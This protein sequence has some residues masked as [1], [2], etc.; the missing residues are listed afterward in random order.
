[1]KALKDYLLEDF[2]IESFV[3]GDELI[4]E[5]AKIGDIHNEYRI[6]VNTDDPGYIPHFHIWD[7]KTKGQKFHTCVKYESC[8]YFHHHCKEDILNT[9]LK[10]ELVSFLN[11]K[12]IVNKGKTNW[13][14]AIDL[15]NMNNS[16]MKVDINQKMP[17]YKLL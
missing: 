4:I 17:N 11:K 8:E 7:F 13:Q 12:S 9:K 5:M 10:K 1:M 15:W 2:D 6:F 14:I 3:N 16:K